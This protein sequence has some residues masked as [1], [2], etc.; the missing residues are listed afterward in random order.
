M[1]QFVDECTVLAG[2]MPIGQ[3][4]QYSDQI[5]AHCP[6]L[7]IGSQTARQREIGSRNSRVDNIET[8]LRTDEDWLVKHEA[9][10]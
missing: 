8:E 7:Q 6:L 3:E 10:Y 2:T 9:I 1:V 4:R 5:A